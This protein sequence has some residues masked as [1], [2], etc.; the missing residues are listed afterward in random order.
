MPTGIDIEVSPKIMSG[1][2]MLAFDLR[3]A[4]AQ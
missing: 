1:C 3:R 4:E 2:A